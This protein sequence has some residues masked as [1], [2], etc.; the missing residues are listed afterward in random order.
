MNLLPKVVIVGRPNVGKSSLFNRI[1]GRRAAVV[2]DREGVTRDRHYQEVSWDHRRFAL[3]DTGGYL[4]NETVDPL[5]AQVREQITSAVDE[6]A[7]V[8]FLVDGLS[9]LTDLDLRFAKVLRESKRPVVLAVNKAESPET[10]LEGWDFLKLGFGEPVM[11]SALTGF[12]VGNMLSR[13]LSLIPASAWKERELDPPNTIRLAILGRPNAGKSTLVNKLLGEERTIVSSLPGTTRD[14]IDCRLQWN[15]YHFILTDTAGLRKKAK[16][17]DDV[18]YFSNMRSLEA[19]R[20][21]HISVVIIDAVAGIGQQDLRIIRQVLAADRGLII[22]MNK[23]DAVEKGDKT[24]DHMVKELKSRYLELEDVPMISISALTGQRVTRLLEEVLQVQK[25]CQRVLGREP[26]VEL[27]EEAIAENPHPP[28]NSRP[29][30]MSRAC[31]VM[32][33]P[34]VVAIECSQPL[35]V[36]DNWKR[37]FIRRLRQNFQLT[38]APVKLNFDRQI[39]LRKDEELDEQL[40]RL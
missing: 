16:V 22:L 14:S 30:L 10:R 39:R 29:V 32:I 31:Q 25:N 4:P 13:L 35:L 26:L 38:G 18:E 27:F 9:G 12:E 37:F 34:I 33:N 5:A 20:R 17:E 21:S 40:D 3:V 28:R 8:I 36:D 7:V 19:I 1:L 15:G 6:A 24:W 2:S 23:W 11:I